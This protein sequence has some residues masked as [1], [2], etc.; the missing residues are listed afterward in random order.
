MTSTS[1]TQHTSV[2]APRG[3]PKRIVD[4]VEHATGVLYELVEAIDQV[5][6]RRPSLLPGWSRAHVVTHLARNADALVNLLTWARTGVEHQAYASRADR[7]ADIEE[8]SGRLLQLLRA[9]LDSA[10]ARFTTACRELP[11]SAWQAE[12]A[13]PRGQPMRADLVPWLRLCELWIHMVDLDLG[14]TFADLPDELAEK[15]IDDSVERFAGR[16]PSFDVEATFPDGRQRR[17]TFNSPASAA[18]AGSSADVLGWLTGR[19]RGEG[20]RGD[21]P[22]LPSWG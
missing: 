11:A 8:G 12:V 3:V 22:D 1:S 21:L 6:V 10:C 20:L 9:D 5:A 14:V 13:T 18:V 17:W 2:P 16:G 7:D 4:A 19:T 15:L